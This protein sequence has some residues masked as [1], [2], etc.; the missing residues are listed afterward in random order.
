MAT[1]VTQPVLNSLRTTFTAAFWN[2][3]NNTPKWYDKISTEIPSASISNTYGWIMDQFAM[4]EWIGPRVAQNM[5]EHAQ[6]IVNKLWEETAKLKRTDVEDDNL[7][8]FSKFVMPSMA[9]AAAK[10]P[11]TRLA[12]VILANGNAFDGKAFFAT[13]HPTFNNTGSGNT[14]YSNLITTTGLDGDG[15][16]KVRAKMAGFTGEN[17]LPLGVRGNLLIVPP[18]LENAANVIANSETYAIPTVT[19]GLAPTSNSATVYNPMKGTF[20]VLVVPELAG[21]D[22]TWYMADTTK[23]VMPF[24]YQPRIPLELTARFNPEDPSVFELDQYVWG[25]RARYELGFSLPYL[26]VKVTA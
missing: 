18:A 5:Q 24:V 20:T 19:S 14:T 12:Q 21:N 8:V 9:R 10:H 4:R 26:C 11:D 2:V 15:A 6:V 13:D 23:P 16:N 25:G 22:T 17:N 3:F 1:I 7:G